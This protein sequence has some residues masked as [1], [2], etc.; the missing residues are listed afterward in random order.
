MSRKVGL[1]LVVL[2]A[3]IG[4]LLLAVLVPRESDTSGGPTPVLVVTQT[5]PGPTDDDLVSRGSVAAV[6][7]RAGE[8]L[9]VRLDM[10]QA[11]TGSP[12]DVIYVPQGDDTPQ[13]PFEVD[14]FKMA[15]GAAEHA[16][17][18]GS[19]AGPGT[20]VEQ[21]KN[22]L[23]ILSSSISDERRERIIGALRSL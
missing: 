8:A 18:V 23:L 15:G 1:G 9:T 22:V 11:D 10:A 7:A 13:P 17:L 5:I 14:V 4:G 2:F 21:R 16:R 12:V 3:L 19:V 20:E 6:F